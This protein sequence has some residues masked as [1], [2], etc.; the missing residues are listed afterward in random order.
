MSNGI[1]M[2]LLPLLLLQQSFGGVVVAVRA[3][4][5]V[6]HRESTAHWIGKLD[7]RSMDI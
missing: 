1:V 3:D 5:I 7:T 6:A 4:V 2:V